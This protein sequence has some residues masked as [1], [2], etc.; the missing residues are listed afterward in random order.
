MWF[1]QSP[2]YRMHF[3]NRARSSCRE[4]ATFWKQKRLLFVGGPVCRAAPG[5]AIGPT[6]IADC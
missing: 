4:E 3:K 2:R 1:A 5:K 6:P